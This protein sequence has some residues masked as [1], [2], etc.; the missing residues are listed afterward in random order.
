MTQRAA[1]RAL[2][3]VNRASTW[4]TP[5]ARIVALASI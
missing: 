1:K 4:T 5:H 2:W 3:R